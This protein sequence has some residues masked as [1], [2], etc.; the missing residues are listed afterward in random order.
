MDIPT[1][2]SKYP[3]FDVLKPERLEL[4]A[5]GLQIEFFPAG[6]VILQQAGEP[7]KFLYVVRTGAVELLDE[8]RVLDL[9]GD[10]EVFGHFSLLSGLGPAF[11]VRAHEDTICYLIEPAM[12]EEVLGTHTGLA[13]LSAT[14]R[15]R[16]VRAVEGELEQ[17][18]DPRHATVDS[19]IKRPPVTCTPTA[20]VR[21]AAEIMA[22]QRVSSLLL[23]RGDGFGIVT[24]RDLRS[25]VLARGRSPDTII[26]E[27]MSYPAIT[28]PSDTLIAEI[29]LLMLERGVHHLPVTGEDGRVIGVVTDTDLLGLEQ[30]TPFKLKSSIERAPNEEALIATGRELP[31]AVCT[32]VEAGLDPVDIGHVVAVTIDTLTRRLIELAIADLGEP[33]AP[34]AWLSLGSEARAEQALLTDQDHALA[35]E[36]RELP[37]DAVDPYFEKVG[38]RVTAGLEA[39]GIPRCRA[40]V[41]A[42]NREWRR[43]VAEWIF[44]FKTWMSDPSR[45]GRAFVGIAF[46]YRSVA[47]PLPIEQT[48][49]EIIRSAPS[50]PM[51]VRRLAMAAVESRPP[52]GF[53]RDVV[54]DSKGRSTGA[55]DV[56]H[57]G[58]TL[59]TN[60]ARAYA[61]GSG[62]TENRTLR[63]LRE[64]ALAGVI[65]EETR[66]GL[67]EAFRLLWQ[68]RLE[69]QCSLVRQGL[70]PD[71]LIDPKA[72]GPLTRQGVK[73]AF[74][75]ID[76]AQ[77]GLASKLGLRTR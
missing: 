45:E 76:R 44:R 52:T 48:L 37:I 73:E 12:A 36:P 14:L 67:D 9:L 49:D 69:H 70:P 72:L 50:N 11:S 77:S 29:V 55:L 3:P 5:R 21:E 18:K 30:E 26:G 31:E 34:W 66:A 46:D 28:V 7:S 40:G 58:I 24:D 23:P 61:I 74:R 13:F 1:F 71:D 32:L 39:V 19:L 51:F 38:E 8:D 68:M 35:Y 33:P 47:G 27:V 62:F 65:D 57:G 56:K 15:R 16:E 42:A 6:T 10:G 41:I 2:L 17:R 64:V 22:S 53:I 60:L 4:V 75:V 63:R 25:R 59:V 20:T 43:P 54:V